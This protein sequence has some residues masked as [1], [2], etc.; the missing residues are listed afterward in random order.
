GQVV[1]FCLV[2]SHG[3]LILMFGETPQHCSA[4]WVVKKIRERILVGF[5]RAGLNKQAS[6]VVRGVIVAAAVSGRLAILVLGERVFDDV[7]DIVSPVFSGRRLLLPFDDLGDLR[8][9][10]VFQKRILGLIVRGLVIGV[11][12]AVYALIFTLLLRDKVLGRAHLLPVS[13]LPSGHLCVAVI[14]FADDDLAAAARP[15]IAK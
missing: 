8:S 1:E 13:L 6:D 2:V 11:A 10:K 7:V 3:G 5:V 9:P 14:A 15:A 4:T 12:G